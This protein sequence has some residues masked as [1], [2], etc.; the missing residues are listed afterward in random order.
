LDYWLRKTGMGFNEYKTSRQTCWAKIR[1]NNVEDIL[2]QAE[3]R[4]QWALF[5]KNSDMS[6]MRAL[7]FIVVLSGSRNQKIPAFKT[8]QKSWEY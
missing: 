4:L 3:I 8:V 5:V 6:L 1:P 2:S 7:S